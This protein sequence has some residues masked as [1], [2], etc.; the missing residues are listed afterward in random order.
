M[1]TVKIT[2]EA[3]ESEESATELL[4]KAL[5]H[6]EVGGEHRESFNQPAARD[7]FESMIKLHELTTVKILKEISEVIDEEV[8]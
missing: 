5:T 2:L 6:H 7:V 8:S 4:I 1:A 3:H